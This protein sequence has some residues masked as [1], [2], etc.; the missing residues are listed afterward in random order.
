M[1]C[2]CPARL[3]DLFPDLWEDDV[4]VR[5][6]KIVMTFLHM[7]TKNVDV[8]KCLFDQLFHS[9]KEDQVSM[10]QAGSWDA[11]RNSLSMFW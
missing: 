6:D 5:P 8:Q 7:R 9:L 1:H 2:D 4:P 10:A 11:T 3:N